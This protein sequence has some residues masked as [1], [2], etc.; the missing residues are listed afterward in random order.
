MAKYQ[1]KPGDIRKYLS[2]FMKQLQDLHR[3]IEEF[4]NVIRKDRRKKINDRKGASAIQFQVGDFV[5]V[6]LVKKRLHSK[7]HM[8]W[9]GPFQIV[10]IINEF[11]YEVESIV[12]N[13]IQEVHAVRLRF[14][15]D[16]YLQITEEM[17]EQFLNDQF[18]YEVEKLIDLKFFK[19]LEFLVRWRGFDEAFDTWES[20]RSILEDV[21]EMVDK[22]IRT[23]PRNKYLPELQTLK[24][25]M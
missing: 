21:P 1:I 14:Y 2:G 8:T 15:E 16:K 23:N 6:A 4:K 12:G 13:Q 5:L 22:F 7:L 25:G 11:V 10:R 3:P 9:T 19:D 20:A 24:R 18:N 17:Q